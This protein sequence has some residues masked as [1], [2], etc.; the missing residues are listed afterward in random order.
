MGNY[1]H[2]KESV[3]EYIK[4]AK[5]HD[6]RKIIPLLKEYLPAKS[7]VLE[8]GSGPGTDWQI[9][10]KS[11]I[12]TGSDNSN[13]F[14]RHL[15]NTNPKGKFI[16]LDA[17]SLLT[18]LKFDAIYSNKVL[19]HLEDLALDNSIARQTEILNPG[20]IVCHTFW[21][22]NDSETYNDLFV[23]YHSDTGLRSL[24]AKGFDT[25]LTK[26][27][28]EFEEGDSILYIGKKKKELP[29]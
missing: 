29:Q 27:Y 22:G 21:R 20:G 15:S 4:M 19:H 11:F 16:Q 17:S 23:N 5:G 13:E 28:K 3:R 18:E 24:F 10:Q 9:L 7:H 6:G 14:L 8:I 26:Y 2:S 1:Y 25:L 12:T